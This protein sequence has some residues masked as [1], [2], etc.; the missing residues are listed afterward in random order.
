MG[1]SSLLFYGFASHLLAQTCTNNRPVT[2]ECVETG[3]R[4]KREALRKLPAF[5]TDNPETHLR[6]AELLM[7]QGDPNGAIE[8]YRAAIHLNP[9]MSEA[10]RGMG[11]VHLDKHEWPLA[12][13]A[14]RISSQLG[15]D[16][17]R[18]WFW[19]GRALLAQ[20]KFLEA[21]EAFSLATQLESQE[22]EIF[23][24]LALA[25]MAQGE[26][27]KAEEALRQTL[28]LKPDF[29]EAHHRLEVVLSARQDPDRLI[30]STQEMLEIYFRRE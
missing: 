8:E 14:L 3:L 16:D 17:G 30:Q 29:S 22:A 26:F 25:Q 2:D 18:T 7:Q 13:D 19:L 12:E 10:F 9:E 11:A 28:Q 23:A 6:L 24:D 1:I 27:L 15:P 20:Q 5:Q 4:Q 21:E